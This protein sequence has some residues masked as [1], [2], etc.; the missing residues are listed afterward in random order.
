MGSAIAQ[1][2]RNK[3]LVTRL[4]TEV[5]QAADLDRLGEVFAAD[6][7]SHN[8]PAG[9]PPGL[10]GV[11]AFFSVFAGALQDLSVAIDVL[12]AEGDLVAV[13]TTTRGRQVGPVLGVE[14]SG[15]PVEIDAVDIVRVEDGRIVEHWGLTNAPR[16]PASPAPPP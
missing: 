5:V 14:P 9:L 4:H 15:E 8:L 7:R 11:T 3:E 6:F 13:R 10:E 1:E 2:E 12:L 16:A